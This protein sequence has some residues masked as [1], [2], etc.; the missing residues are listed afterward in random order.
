MRRLRLSMRGGRE[1]VHGALDY[2][3][4]YGDPRDVDTYRSVATAIEG[5]KQKLAAFDDTDVDAAAKAEY[6]AIE[7]AFIEM[8]K[9]GRTPD[10]IGQDLVKW[11]AKYKGSIRVAAFE[12]G[13]TDKKLLAVYKKAKEGGGA[14][15]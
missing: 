11:A 14:P 3:T 9:N 12:S 1:N 10:S 6:L 15:R 4:Q 7:R 13:N 8:W 5:L 2:L